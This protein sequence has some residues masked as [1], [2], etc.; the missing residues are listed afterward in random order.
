MT[1]LISYEACAS[2][3]FAVAAPHAAAC[4][5][6]GAACAPPAPSSSSKES[7]CRVRVLKPSRYFSVGH[8]RSLTA[9]DPQPLRTVAFVLDSPLHLVSD[10]AQVRTHRTH[11]VRHSFASE[12]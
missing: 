4:S 1:N 12:H 8:I 2:A 3:K 10:S 6:M 11:I 5:G 9:T 7:S